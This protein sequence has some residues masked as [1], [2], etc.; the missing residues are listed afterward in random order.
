MEGFIWPKKGRKNKQEVGEE[1]GRDKRE[2]EEE[3]QE[4]D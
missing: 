4:E 1:M 3:R 2:E